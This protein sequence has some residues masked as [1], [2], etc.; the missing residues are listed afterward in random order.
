MAFFLYFI[1]EKDFYTVLSLFFQT[2]HTDVEKE[3]LDLLQKSLKLCDVEHPGARQIVY[4]YRSGLI[5][6]R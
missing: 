1:M 2:C 6:Q 5:H 3:V 4:T